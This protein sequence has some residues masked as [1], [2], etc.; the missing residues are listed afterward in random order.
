[1]LAIAFFGAPHRIQDRNATYMPNSDTST[2]TTY[3]RMM[4][5]PWGFGI[6]LWFTLA[7]CLP[8]LIVASVG[9]SRVNADYPDLQA[10]LGLGV[11]M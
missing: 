11:I 10:D 3:H 7:W 8:V 5:Q 9:I 4:I 2:G 6:T 1:M